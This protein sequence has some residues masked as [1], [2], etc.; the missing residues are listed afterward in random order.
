MGRAD[1]APNEEIRETG[2]GE[3]PIEDLWSYVWGLVDEREEAE[4]EL[5]NNAGNGTALLIDVGHEFWCHAGLC[6]SLNRA[7]RTEGAG[8]GNRNDRYGDDGVEDGRKHFNA[9]KVDGQDEWGGL[10][11]CTGGAQENI[12]IRRH[13][14]TQDE[15]RNHVEEGDTPENLLGCQRNGL[16]WVRGFGS[17]K[18][19]ELGSSE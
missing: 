12:G 10:G 8:V 11:V 15:E 4:E 6:E 17:C 7:R 2:E 16:S 9:S 3:E 18:P 5:Q 14:E 19:D 1:R 13:N